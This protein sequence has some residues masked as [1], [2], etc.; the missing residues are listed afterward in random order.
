[1]CVDGDETW[2]KTW[3]YD[4]VFDGPPPD[5]HPKPYQDHRCVVLQFYG[6]DQQGIDPT[7][8]AGRDNALFL[9][10]ENNTFSVKSWSFAKLHGAFMWPD[11][12]V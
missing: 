4:R 2:W 10:L 1:M 5:Y 9:V 3:W 12:P 11:R 8:V 7:T 6:T